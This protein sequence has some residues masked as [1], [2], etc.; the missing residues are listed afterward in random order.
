[1]RMRSEWCEGGAMRGGPTK[2]DG[3]PAACMCARQLMRIQEPARHDGL[4]LACSV[5]QLLTRIRA[6]HFFDRASKKN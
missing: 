3:L 2:H 4:P 1:M 5:A 6:H